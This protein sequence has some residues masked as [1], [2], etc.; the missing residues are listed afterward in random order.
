M[1]DG[2]TDFWTSHITQLRIPTYL[3]SCYQIIFTS[4][5][6]CG[7]IDI[8]L[9]YKPCIFCLFVKHNFKTL[10]NCRDGITKRLWRNHQYHIPTGSILYLCI[11][12]THKPTRISWNIK[13][14]SKCQTW[15]IT[16]LYIVSQCS[17]SFVCHQNLVKCTWPPCFALQSGRTVV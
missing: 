12:W 11:A 10:D 14:A 16:C 3:R 4:T 8:K 13:S 15:C 1:R 6:C 7:K 9:K 2:I 5:Y 17:L